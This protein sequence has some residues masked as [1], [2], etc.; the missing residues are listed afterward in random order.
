MQGSLAMDV[1]AVGADYYVSNMH[2]WFCNPRGAAFLWVN[3][4][5]VLGHVPRV[6]PLV[7]SHGS[8]AG[9]LSDFIWDGELPSTHPHSPKITPLPLCID[10]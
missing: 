5:S 2:K 4:A 3:P 7:V 9:F 6:Q 8:G 10:G 1:A